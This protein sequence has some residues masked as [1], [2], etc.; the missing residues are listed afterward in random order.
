MVL[1]DVE[2]APG[3]VYITCSFECVHKEAQTSATT[4]TKGGR[5]FPHIFTSTS[6]GDGV[7]A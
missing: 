6:N 3:N 2:V 5:A 4:V 7:L 1:E